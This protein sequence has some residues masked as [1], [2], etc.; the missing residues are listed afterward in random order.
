MQLK[1]KLVKKWDECMWKTCIWNQKRR[2]ITLKN[3]LVSKS[4]RII[5]IFVPIKVS[6][7][8]SFLNNIKQII[9]IWLLSSYVCLERKNILI[10]KYF[11]CL[12][13]I[14]IVYS[15]ITVTPQSAIHVNQIYTGNK[16]CIF[17]LLHILSNICWNHKYHFK[18]NL[19]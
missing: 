5:K 12:H 4:K 10:K 11:N 6:D 8:H 9:C 19:F 18:K 14:L 2:K 17:I 1:R 7:L 15:Q 16:N 3:S 13:S